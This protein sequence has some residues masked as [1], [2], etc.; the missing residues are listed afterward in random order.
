[1][2]HINS[3]LLT[4]PLKQQAHIY[5]QQFAAEQA[6]IEKGK[7]VY[8]NTLA[9]CAVRSYLQWLAIENT[10]AQ[11]ECW[12]PGFRAIF[13][14]ADLDLPQ[15]GKK[16]E[17]IPVLPGQN[18]L[19]IPPEAIENRLGYV[20]VQFREEL[21]EVELL[22]FLPAQKTRHEAIPLT[23]LKS[24]DDLIDTIE[25]GEWVENL[26]QWFEGVFQLEW[27]PVESLVPSLRLKTIPRQNTVSRG[28]IM[29]W[30]NK[31]EL[32][33]VVRITKTTLG[34][35]EVCLRIY[36]YGDIAHLLPGLQV[37]LLD[38]LGTVCMEQQ[39]GKKTNWIQLDFSCQPDDIF[40]V[41]ISLGEMSMTEQFI[42]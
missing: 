2:K 20:G 16:L 40:G 37:E 11:S 42:V 8:L 39:A 33:L 22:G 3:Q 6:T 21:E 31:P 32:I 9:V 15:L 26:R 23:Q 38:E 4:V 24:L 29:H 13:N 36:P 1:M 17:C 14:V 27:Q 34:K 19:V 5:A 18:A 10:V 30:E 41:R 7:Q 28:K 35:V 25:R 12:H